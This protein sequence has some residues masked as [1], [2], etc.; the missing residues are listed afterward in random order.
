ML[1]HEQHGSVGGSLWLSNAANRG[2]VEGCDS[3][4]MHIAHKWLGTVNQERLCFV[5]HHLVLSSTRCFE[6]KRRD[7]G[8]LTA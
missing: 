8:L 4:M 3:E 7:R 1:L 5:A 6:R 2:Q